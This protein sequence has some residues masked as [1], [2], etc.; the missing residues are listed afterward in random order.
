MSHW[1]RLPDDVR[2]A[3]QRREWENT[4]RLRER[5]CGQRDPA[6]T[7]NLRAPSGPQAVEDLTHFKAFISAWRNHGARPDAA[8]TIEWETR[9]YRQIGAHEVPVRLRIARPSELIA[10]LGPEAVARARGWEARMTPV[11]ETDGRLYDV[12]VAHLGEVERLTIEDA[13]RL[14]ATL[15]QLHRD[16]G[17]G[18][19]LRALP[20]RGID[21]KFIEQYASLIQALLDVVHDGA[22]SAEGGL[23]SWLGCLP[24]PNSW[25]HVRPLWD[26]TRRALG[27]LAMMQLPTRALLEH[28]L[29][30]SRVLIV[31]N[32]QSGL[33]LPPLDRTVAVFGGGRNTAWTT[34]PWLST[35]TV[36]YWGDLDTWGFAFLNDVR[37]RQ[38]HTRS[39]LMD[40]ATLEAHRDRMTDEATPCTDPLPALTADEQ[41]LRHTLASGG[42]GQTRLEQ[43]R[44]SA[45]WIA[46]ALERWER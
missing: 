43:E 8:G 38:P 2:G 26:D 42:P 16:L 29:P 21:T 19:Y 5:L 46:G 36:G 1:G 24:V 30:G 18:Q 41:T 33:A 28:P 35:R 44:L 17:H 7:E 14:A 23:S 22:V 20:V 34:A 32:R 15:P 37:A 12:L 6:I 11:L 10:F 40:R 45:D 9:Q 31:E 3:L 13:N 39:L 25:L 27:G 4:T